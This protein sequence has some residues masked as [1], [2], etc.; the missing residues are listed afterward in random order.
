MD[1]PVPLFD[2]VQ[3]WQSELPDPSALVHQIAGLLAPAHATQP[4]TVHRALHPANILVQRAGG[5]WQCTVARGNAPS[6][7]G[8]PFDRAWYA[9]PQQARGD[10]PDA[11]DDVFAL[12]VL[13]YQLLTRNFSTGRPGGSQWRKRL[14]ESGVPNAQVE[15]LESCFEDDAQYRPADA[16]VLASRLAESLRKPAPV[17]DLVPRGRARRSSVQELFKTLEQDVKEQPKLLTNGLG[18]KLV[19]LPA[20]TIQ[21]GSPPEEAGRRDNEGPQ[22]EVLLPNAFYLAVHTVTQAQFQQLLRR[23]PSKFNATHGGGPDHPVEMVTWEE[24]VEFCQRLSQVAEEKAAGRKYRLPTEA[25]WEYACRAGTTTPFSFGAALSAE[26]ANF[27]GTFPFGGAGRG[28]FADKTLPVGSYPSN[29]FGLFDMHGNVWEWCADWLHSDYYGRSPK[30]NPQGPETGAF[31][32]IRG[33]CWR[34]QAGT[35]RSAYRNGLSPRNRD[36]FTGFRVVVE[37]GS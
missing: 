29:N 20:A 7:P 34:S 10:S 14:L 19:L 18:M 22:H 5:S 35:C 16:G 31:R 28:L 15:L 27:D 26:Q 9:S 33:G 12:G 8:E 25:E 17:E 2:A 23:N 36:R 24:A 13:W 30:R 32:L 3:Q 11:R 37:V 6:S 4:A 21:M 1:T